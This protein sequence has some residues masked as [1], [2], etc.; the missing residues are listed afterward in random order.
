MLLVRRSRVLPHSAGDALTN[1]NPHAGSARGLRVY[2]ISVLLGVFT[3]AVVAARAVAAVVLAR[4][5]LGAAW[6]NET[7]C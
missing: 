2:S 3:V 1:V 5:R 4:V 7:R 6:I